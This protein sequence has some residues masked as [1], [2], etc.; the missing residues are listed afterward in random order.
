MVVRNALDADQVLELLAR[1]P[2]LI[3][4]AASGLT[5]AQLA[6]APGAGEWS[7]HQVL[8]HLRACADVWGGAMLAIAEEGRPS[9]RAVNPLTWIQST[10]YLSRPFDS[11]LREFREQRQRLL[12]RLRL[13]PP[14]GWERVAEVTGAGRPLQR[15]V[16][17][18]GRWLA[19]HER[20][21][22]RQIRDTAAAVGAPGP[23]R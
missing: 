11:S 22:R 5:P 18:Y 10:D 17:F 1:T 4:V 21:H 8:A 16:L 13:L 9:F 23:R 15:S 7:L 3:A 6:A 2:E 14:G 20:S 12:L 19:G